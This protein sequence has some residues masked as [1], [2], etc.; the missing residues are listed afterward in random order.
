MNILNNISQA[1]KD[2]LNTYRLSQS[3]KQADIK[4][5]SELAAFDF[6]VDQDDGNYRRLSQHSRDLAPYKYE[7]AVKISRAF[8]EK[9]PLYKRLLEIPTDSMA[10]AGVRE[11]TD[12]PKLEEVG[13]GLVWEP[14]GG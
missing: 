10:S 9:D 5:S 6:Q 8:K 3:L 1:V 7:R 12:N 13:E 4:E 11:K 14:V 2:R